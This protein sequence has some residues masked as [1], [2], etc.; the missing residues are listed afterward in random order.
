[1]TPTYGIKSMGTPTPTLEERVEE[2][3]DQVALLMEAVFGEGGG[4][5]GDNGFN[6]PEDPDPDPDPDPE[7]DPVG[8]EPPEGGHDGPE[9]PTMP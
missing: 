5:V 3:E 9:P 4:G 7:P 1:M 6:T 2:L 8:D